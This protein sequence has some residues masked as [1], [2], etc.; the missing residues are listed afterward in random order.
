MRRK[1]PKE[2]AE[3]FKV[4]FERQTEEYEKKLEE[5]RIARLKAAQETDVSV[6]EVDRVEEIS[7]TWQ[8]GNED[9]VKLKEG[10]DGTVGRL[11]KAQ[12]AM[13]VVG[14]K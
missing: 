8:R 12:K 7:G 3:H 10:M 1:A 4:A 5:E 11:E 14:E 13:E 2:T 9:L 6:G